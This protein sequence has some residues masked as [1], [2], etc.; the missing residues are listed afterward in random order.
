[1]VLACF[2]I[3]T[4]GAQEKVTKVSQSFKVDKNVTI[5]LNTSHCNIVFDTWNKSEVSIEAFVE[6]DEL[7]K[8]E[9]D[10]IAK[11][12]KLDIDGSTDLVTINTR[13]SYAPHTYSFDASGQYSDEVKRA[14]KNLKYELAELPDLDLEFNFNFNTF[15]SSLHFH[16]SKNDKC[17][18]E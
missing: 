8:E 7:S 5:D 11:G 10:E 13:G 4:L 14:L 9:L 6:S 16:F 3:T 1:M 15:W 12:W 18:C 2:A 17:N